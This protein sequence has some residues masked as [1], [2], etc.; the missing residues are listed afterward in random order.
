[1]LFPY[2]KGAL[3]HV[4]I[5]SIFAKLGICLQWIIIGG[6]GQKSMRYSDDCI[7]WA[8]NLDTVS[9]VKT[10]TVLGKSTRIHGISWQA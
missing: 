2:D 10:S 3:C 6:N 7:A 1:M 9:V 4:G 8:L 5:D